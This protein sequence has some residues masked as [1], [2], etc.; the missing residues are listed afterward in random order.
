MQSDIAEE[1]HDSLSKTV[2][3]SQ[4]SA[5]ST[6]C[7]M[8]HSMKAARVNQIIVISNSDRAHGLARGA[9]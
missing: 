9:V 6:V 7:E 3:L 5:G 2:P 4:I 8:A 1:V